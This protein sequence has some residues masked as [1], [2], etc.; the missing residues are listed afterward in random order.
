MAAR[1][2]AGLQLIVYSSGIG[3]YEFSSSEYKHWD[4]IS[5]WNYSNM[6]TLEST[7]IYWDK[8]FSIIYNYITGN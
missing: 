6:E 3:I 1:N 4:I 8:L 2:A 7:V 5:S